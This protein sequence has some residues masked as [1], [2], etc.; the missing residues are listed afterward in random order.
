MEEKIKN[1]EI[2]LSRMSKPLQEKMRVAKYIPAN[3]KTVLDVGCADGTVTLALAHLFPHIQFLGIDLNGDFIEKA[4]RSQAE[5]ELS[6]VHFEKIYLRDLLAR[7][8]KF[9]AAIFVS[10][11][12]E[13]F[14]YGEG[15]SSVFKALADAHELLHPKGEIII[16]DMI[17]SE[18]KKHTSYMAESIVSKV[19]GIPSLSQQI[20]DFEKH[21]GSVD[22][23]YKINHF[24]LK[25]MYTENWDREVRE[26]YLPVSFDQYEQIFSLLG[27]E[28]QLK[29]YYL[30]DFLKEK[31]R[32]D[33]N[34]TNDEL[35][36]LKSTGFLVAKK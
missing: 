28:L 25:Y 16:R 36:T 13:F 22:N 2:Y 5:Q 34:L 7:E 29:D 10:V 26:H 35:E 4:T 24:L 12:H 19:H 32:T 18:Y 21:F 6:N 31:W 20:K 3:A 27:M 33:F 30:I 11:L 14:S 15:I 17:F 23:I 1:Q 8:Q 9:D